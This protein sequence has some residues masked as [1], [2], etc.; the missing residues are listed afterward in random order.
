MVFYKICVMVICCLFSVFL[1]KNA[2]GRICGKGNHNGSTG[3]LVPHSQNL[4]GETC[5]WHIFPEHNDMPETFLVFEEFEL[6]SQDKCTIGKYNGSVLFGPFSGKMGTFS[7][8][9][10]YLYLD[11]V[12]ETEKTLLPRKF[13]LH[14]TAEKCDYYIDNQKGRIVSPLYHDTQRSYEVVICTWRFR[15]ISGVDLMY[16]IK[17]DEFH[18]TNSTLH[19]K[20]DNHEKVLTGTDVPSEFPIPEHTIFELHVNTK[21]Q[22]EKFSLD[23]VYGEHIVPQTATPGDVGPTTTPVIINDIS[24]ICGKTDY[25]EESGVITLGNTLHTTIDFDCFWNINCENIPNAKELHIQVVEFELANED[26][27]TVLDSSGKVLF[28]SYHGKKEPFSILTGV[29]KLKFHVEISKKQKFVRKLKIAY[30]AKDCVNQ[31]TSENGIVQLPIFESGKSKSVTCSW[32]FSS[33]DKTLIRKI[34]FMKHKF[35]GKLSL[36]G[37]IRPKNTYTHNNLPYALAKEN[38]VI[39]LTFDTNSDNEFMFV[40][41]KVSDCSSFIE[42]T[43]ETLISS[44][45]KDNAFDYWANCFWIVESPRDSVIRLEIQKLN[46]INLQD[47]VIVTDGNSEKAPLLSQMNAGNQYR[48]SKKEIISQNN[49][50]IIFFHTQSVHVSEFEAKLSISKCPLFCDNGYCML[51]KWKCDGINDCGDYTDEKDCNKTIVILPPVEPPRESKTSDS[52]NGVSNLAIG[53][54]VPAAFIGGILVTIACAAGKQMYR[55][56]VSQ[57]YGAFPIFN[58]P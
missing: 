11:V 32:T 6:D 16:W 54:A 4:A 47:Y 13:K 1:I 22:N 26:N 52:S 38:G 23:Y 30:N 8:L 37:N 14:F 39:K 21:I 2:H 41:E 44:A 36:E 31:L 10:G 40:Y 55:N 7:I 49:S 5:K 58:D 27:V 25:V 19:I 28:A 20:H 35:N 15:D 51:E 29:L 9:A 45:L 24:L 42:L 43:K 56:R 18:L 33:S 12:L 50:I 34:S 3:E 46:L 57:D 48:I 53:L 17:F